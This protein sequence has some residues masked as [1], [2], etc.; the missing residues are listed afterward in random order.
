[1]NLYLKGNKNTWKLTGKGTLE[2]GVRKPEACSLEAWRDLKK[3]ARTASWVASQPPGQPATWPAGQAAR[4]W[5]EAGF[6]D[7]FF[8]L[9]NKKWKALI[10]LRK[11]D[12]IVI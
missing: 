6:F 11:T 8:Q 5:R 4:T 2:S 12:R 10:L 3:E 1:M 9:F 7:S